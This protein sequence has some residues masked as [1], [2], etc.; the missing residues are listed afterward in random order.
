MNLWAYN[1]NNKKSIW[2]KSFEIDKKIK[3]KKRS[4]TNI[5]V[6]EDNLSGYYNEVAKTLSKRED[7]FIYS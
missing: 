2:P 7:Y 6:F 1:R 3:K 4:N 5:L